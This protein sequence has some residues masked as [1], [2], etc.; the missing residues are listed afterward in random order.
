[1]QVSNSGF[2]EKVFENLKNLAEDAHPLEI[3][4]H[5]T[6]ILIWGL[7]MSTTMRAAIHLGPNYTDILEVTQILITEILNVKTIDCTFASWSTSS[8]AHD[9]AI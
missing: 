5:K 3:Q 4:A 8:L 1:M 2:L 7:F 6:N 9:Q